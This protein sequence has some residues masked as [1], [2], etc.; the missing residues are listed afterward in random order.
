MLHEHSKSGLSKDDLLIKARERVPLGILG[1]AE[2]CKGLEQ[3]CR[4]QSLGQSLDGFLCLAVM[5]VL[6]RLQLPP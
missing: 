4:T 3:V 5:H 1:S 2:L 6:M